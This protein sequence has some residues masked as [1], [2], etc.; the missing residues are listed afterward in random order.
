[1]EMKIKEGMSMDDIISS[2]IPKLIKE[3][4][5][6]LNRDKLKKKLQI[7]HKRDDVL[8][9]AKFI[10]VC[11]YRD[12]CNGTDSLIISIRFNSNKYSSSTI[13]KSDI[14]YNTRKELPIE[15]IKKLIKDIE[16]DDL[17]EQAEWLDSNKYEKKQQNKIDKLSI[18]ITEI[19]SCNITI[20]DVTN[21]NILDK[22]GIK[23]TRGDYDSFGWLTAVLHLEKGKI[24]IG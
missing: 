22:N 9:K 10:R 19:L 2:I 20:P 16:D 1:M 6:K 13:Y 11:V 14:Y 24:L 5:F 17:I 7:L 21:L 12:F 15:Y 23:I 3:S 8:L 4:Q 18:L